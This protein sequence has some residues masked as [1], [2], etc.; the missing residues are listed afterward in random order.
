[1]PGD[2][3]RR[4]WHAVAVPFIADDLAAWLI[5]LLGDASRRKLTTF[6]LGTEQDR[7]LRQA[8]AAAVRQ[9]AAEL[10]P[11]DAQR[12]EDLT[13]VI[14][15]VFSVE[16]APDPAAPRTTLLEQLRAGVSRQLAILDDREITSTGQSSAEQFGITSPVIAE[17]LAAE[18]TREILRC[19]SDDGPL[20]PLAGQLNHD[21]THLQGQQTA[22][23]LAELTSAVL[24]LAASGP[25]HA[26]RQ[27]RPTAVVTGHSE[28]GRFGYEARTEA[29]RLLIVPQDPYLSALRAGGR[30][31]AQD[32]WHSLWEDTFAWPELDVK[33]VNNTVETVF[34]HEAQFRVR[35][36]RIDRRPVPVIH[37]AAYTGDG[38]G[39]RS[40]FPLEN[41][42]WG[43][44]GDCVLRFHLE[45]PDVH[46]SVT[47]EF[48]WPF[49]GEG[50]FEDTGPLIAALTEAG[51]DVPNLPE[52]DALYYG[53]SDVQHRALGPFT[54]GEAVI[55]GI[56]EYTQTELD[57]TRT[58]RRNPVTIPLVLGP[59][60]VG[61]PIPPSWSYQVRLRAEGRDYTVKR[62]ISQALAPGEADRFLFAIAAPKASVHDFDLT[63][64]YN[65]TERLDCADVTLEFFL[66]TDDANLMHRA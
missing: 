28:E 16:A 24:D 62:D 51:V 41:V 30:L 36:S 63:L 9:V 38:T 39:W 55:S 32:Y 59:K 33:V 5:G 8:A 22:A 66:S 35:R 25:R 13:Q 6:I 48:A 53:L 23:Q 52:A 4:I 20:T 45:R 64:L 26:P 42:G 58:R 7:A 37:G 10:C 50:F 44:M 29:G 60:G 57:G 2:R 31:T 27:T 12:A 46:A 43:P 54:T 49:D 19:G 17:K 40:D 56:L 65:S 61:A 47:G 21:A 15:H 3:R 14:S 34:F 18:L 1:M 11:D